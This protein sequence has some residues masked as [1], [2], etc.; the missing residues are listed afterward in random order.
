MKKV[1]HSWPYY[2]E[3]PT[4]IKT[5][6]EKLRHE[7]DSI[8]NLANLLKQD[9]DSIKFLCL[10]FNQYADEKDVRI[11]NLDISKFT[12]ALISIANSDYSCWL[13]SF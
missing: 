13:H 2:Q 7:C 8:Q 1:I 10:M 5:D 11:N 3:T 4:E 9:L 12:N 6:V